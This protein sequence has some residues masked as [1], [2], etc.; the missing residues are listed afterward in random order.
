M[1]DVT[2]IPD[3]LSH[4][5]TYGGYPVPFVQMYFDGK[6]DFRVIDPERAEQCLKEKLCAICGK[7]LGEFCYFIGSSLCKEN[8][9]FPDA[10]MHEQCADFASKACPFVS[11]RKD[12]YSTRSLDETVT[13]I[14]E[15]ASSG[16]PDKMY[17]FETRTKTVRRVS[18]NGNPF[19]QAGTWSR[20]TE[21]PTLR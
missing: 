20:I 2:T 8:H 17:I 13:T 10:P 14:L 3:F 15:M 9:L 21:I 1:A 12:E 18:V 11:G 16:R 7:R 4:L 19:I 6:P 5:K